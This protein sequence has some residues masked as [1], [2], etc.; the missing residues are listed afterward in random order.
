[1]SQKQRTTQDIAQENAGLVYR[2][3]QLQYSIRQTQKDLD[4]INDRLV[5][6]NVEYVAATEL[7]K[8]VQEKVAAEKAKEAEAKSKAEAEAAKDAQAEQQSPTP[9]E[10]SSDKSN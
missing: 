9:V 4:A 6:L 2:A 8:Q 10:V 3:G 1:M 5:A 7:E